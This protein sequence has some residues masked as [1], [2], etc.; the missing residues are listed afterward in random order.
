LVGYLA[1][2][3]GF[4]SSNPRLCIR[5]VTLQRAIDFGL[6]TA[7]CGMF[8]EP[9]DYIRVKPERHWPFDRAIVVRTPG[10]SLAFLWCFRYVSGADLIV[11]EGGQMIRAVGGDEVG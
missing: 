2:Y 11:G 10:K 5:H 1:V 6:I 8:F 4:S 7:L 3:D 9:L